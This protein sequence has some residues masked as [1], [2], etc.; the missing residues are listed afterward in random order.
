MNEGKTIL[1]QS[2]PP[3]ASCRHG[4]DRILLEIRREN[5]QNETTIPS[6]VSTMSMP[7]KRQAY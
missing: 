4:H 7:T 2:E 5:R 6:T 3:L 1:Y